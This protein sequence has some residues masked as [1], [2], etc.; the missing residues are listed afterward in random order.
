MQIINFQ[1]DFSMILKLTYVYIRQVV[2]TPT[3]RP[4]NYWN[5][6]FAPL[7]ADSLVDNW[8]WYW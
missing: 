1:R 7:R 2:K 3:T 6:M 8:Y 5:T 4:D